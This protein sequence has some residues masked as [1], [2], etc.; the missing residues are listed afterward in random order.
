MNKTRKIGMAGM[1]KNYSQQ[2]RDMAPDIVI[3]QLQWKSRSKGPAKMVYNE[4]TANRG[5]NTLQ[6]CKKNLSWRKTNDN[7]IRTINWKFWKNLVF[8]WGDTSRTFKKSKFFFLLKSI[9]KLFKNI[10]IHQHSWPISW[11][12]NIFSGTKTLRLVFS[13]LSFFIR[14]SRLRA[15]YSTD[16]LEWNGIL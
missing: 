9:E 14:P 1:E 11:M 13:K 5:F 3:I 16:L 7:L 2:E 10:N 15:N 12:E 6:S 4:K 8:K